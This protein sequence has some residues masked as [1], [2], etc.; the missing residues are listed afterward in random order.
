MSGPLEAG[1]MQVH[2]ALEAAFHEHQVALLDRDTAGARR[3]FRVFAERLRQ[4][5]ADEESHVLPAYARI[6]G[7][8]SKSPPAQFETE[9]RK[10]LTFVAEFEQKLAELEGDPGAGRILGLLDRESWFKNLMHH[11][12]LRE[13]RVL[14]PRL[15]E[16]LS[17]DE[18][19]QILARCGSAR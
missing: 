17:P 4:H 12:D 11:H 7:E 1:M 10:L 13:A 5:I 18:Q 9:H 2:I 6:G 16:A 14:Y 19:Q 15:G 3:T 8:D